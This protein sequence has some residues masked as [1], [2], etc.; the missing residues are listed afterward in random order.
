MATTIAAPA[1]AQATRG[2][3]RDA[4][5]SANAR[6]PYTAML[7]AE[8]PLGKLNPPA[9]VSDSSGRGRETSSFTSATVAS[10]T[11][12]ATTRVTAERQRPRSASPRAAASTTPMSTRVEPTR[13]RRTP[14]R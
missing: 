13:R 6:Q 12:Y 5:A 10:V 11:A 3:P 4:R 14:S 7:I 8:W 1:S 9:S 2:K